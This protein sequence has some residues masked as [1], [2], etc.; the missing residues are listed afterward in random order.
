MEKTELW[1]YESSLSQ[2]SGDKEA[3]DFNEEE[4]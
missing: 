2:R 3:L 1:Q 4:V